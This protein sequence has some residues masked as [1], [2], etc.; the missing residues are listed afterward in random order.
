M[1]TI[2]S[3][4]YTCICCQCQEQFQST[5]KNSFTCNKCCPTKPINKKW[6][7]FEDNFKM[8][9]ESKFSHDL[10]LMDDILNMIKTEVFMK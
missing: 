6:K 8:K 4:S 3:E 5:N 7:Q 1:K 10:R 2:K 9:F